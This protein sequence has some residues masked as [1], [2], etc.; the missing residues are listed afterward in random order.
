M[1]GFITWSVTKWLKEMVNANYAR[2]LRT[3]LNKSGKQN[4]T[5]QHLCSQLTLISQIIH[6][7]WARHVGPWWEA[8]KTYKRHSS[9]DLN[10]WRY[11]YWPTSKKLLS[12]ALWRHWVPSVS[13]VV[14]QKKFWTQKSIKKMALI[15]FWNMKRLIK[16]DRLEKGPTVNSAFFY[17]I[18]RQI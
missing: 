6:G 13:T 16:I 1:Y 8:G 11:Q 7:G 5:K 4:P 3:V 2:I 10:I 12:H 14:L 18:L 9:V 15:L 17:Q